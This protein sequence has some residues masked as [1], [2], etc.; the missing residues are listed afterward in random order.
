MP[1]TNK[2]KRS[3]DNLSNNELN[4]SNNDDDDNINQD[5]QKVK[6]N[7]F[8][9]SDDWD[10]VEYDQTLIPKRN[11]SGELVF[12][13]YPKFRPNLTPKEVIQKGT[14]W[15]AEATFAPLDSHVDV[16]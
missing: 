1:T 6:K 15:H 12:K 5:G 2:K 14:K 16:V 13:D 11:S 8:V 7:K 10:D 3:L 9:N 4:S